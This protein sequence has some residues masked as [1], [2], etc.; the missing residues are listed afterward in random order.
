IT[1]QCQLDGSGFSPCG[2]GAT[3]T[4]PYPGPLAPGNHTFKVEAVVNSTASSPAAYTWTIVKASPTLTLTQS[5]APAAGSGTSGTAIPAS[6]TTA[7]LASAS[8]PAASGTI[9]FKY[10]QQA[11]APTSCTNGGTTIGTAS[12]AGNGS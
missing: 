3:G 2:S 6:A 7:V 1:F 4:I 10:F 12:I 5:E 8:S 9:T 11:T